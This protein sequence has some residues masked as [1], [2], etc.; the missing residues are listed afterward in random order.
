VPFG[1]GI[2]G[3]IDH[4]EAKRDLIL[5]GLR[6]FQTATLESDFV[7]TDSLVATAVIDDRTCA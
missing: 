1:I 3:P 6:A 7:D 2:A 4:I 5:Q